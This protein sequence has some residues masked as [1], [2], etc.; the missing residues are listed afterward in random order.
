[1]LFKSQNSHK[2]VLWRW[3]FPQLFIRNCNTQI[4]VLATAGHKIMPTAPLQEEC[5]PPLMTQKKLVHTVTAY[6]LG[7]RAE[8]ICPANYIQPQLTCLWQ[9]SNL[10]TV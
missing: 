1:M 8:V 10:R 7:L 3:R 9:L 6:E 4:L 2:Q 5:E